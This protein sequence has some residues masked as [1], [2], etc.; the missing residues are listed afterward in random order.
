MCHTSCAC[1]SS[2]DELCPS[3]PSLHHSSAIKVILLFLRQAFHHRCLL[4]LSQSGKAPGLFPPALQQ[5]K[6]PATVATLSWQGS[7]TTHIAVVSEHLG[8]WMQL[9]WT[10][11]KLSCWPNTTPTCSQLFCYEQTA[12]K[13]LQRL[14]QRTSFSCLPFPDNVR[15]GNLPSITLNRKRHSNCCKYK[16]QGSPVCQNVIAAVSR[17][18]RH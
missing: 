5:E 13:H 14:P 1:L 11:F 4:L 12:K 3:R 6:L 16:S 8:A 17:S 7:C 9:S 15:L 2:G 18:S 10:L